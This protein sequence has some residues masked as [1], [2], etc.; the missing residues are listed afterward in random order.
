MTLNMTEKLLDKVV[1][2]TFFCNLDCRINRHLLGR[3]YRTYR[4]T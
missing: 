1:Q 4:R 3:R 2:S